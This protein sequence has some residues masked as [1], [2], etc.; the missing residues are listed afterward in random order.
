MSLSEISTWSHWIQLEFWLPVIPGLWAH[1]SCRLQVIN[2]I[3]SHYACTAHKAGV[4]YKTIGRRN[5][6]WW[7][8]LEMEAIKKQSPS[9]WSST[10]GWWWGRWRISPKLHKFEDN[11]D[12]SHHLVTHYCYGSGSFVF[13]VLSFLMVFVI[14]YDVSLLCYSTVDSVVPRLLI[15]FSFWLLCPCQLCLFNCVSSCFSHCVSLHYVHVSPAHHICTVAPSCSLA[16]SVLSI[17]SSPPWSG[18][19]YIFH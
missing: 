11:W 2:L 14:L 9:F 15:L 5:N 17:K 16:P 18:I 4:G 7:D 10:Q 3:W 1:V 12:H 13:S 6:C 19:K 8:H